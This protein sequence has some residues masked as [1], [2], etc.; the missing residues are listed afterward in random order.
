MKKRDLKKLFLLYNRVV[1][2]SSL[3]IGGGPNFA[4]PGWKNFDAVES[5]LNHDPIQF[6]PTVTLPARD[7]TFKFI[8]S[9][10]CLEHL[11]D[12]TVDRIF[13][14]ARRII[15]PD[16]QLL[17]KLPDFD[18]ALAAWRARDPAFFTDAHWGYHFVSATWPRR[19]V[20]DDLDHRAAML[21]CGYWNQAYGSFFAGKGSENDPD[22]YHGPPVLPSET[23]KNWAAE[24]TTPHALASRLREA[25]DA[26]ETAPVFNHQ[27][28]W[29]RDELT[30]LLGR[31][32][33]A[34]V[35]MDNQK[36]R[37]QF[38]TVPAINAFGDV[39]M[40]CLARPVS[41]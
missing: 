32:G 25:V 36:L 29:S 11:T 41:G 30:R 20:E 34:V 22:A 31:H 6:S 33:F 1:P 24:D 10:H 7:G 12:A 3:N 2:A 23:L 16:G 9:S 15:R 14:E 13:Q 37:Q 21:F 18:G 8:Y 28:G 35:S 27:N 38:W 17:L 40:Y 26:A 5:D 19:G 39:S 4:F